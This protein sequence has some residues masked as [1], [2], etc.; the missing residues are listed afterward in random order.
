MELTVTYAIRNQVT[1]KT[2]STPPTINLI[3]FRQ[4]FATINNAFEQN[5]KISRT[6][7][8]LAFWDEK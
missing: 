8:L 7:S 2:T 5:K 1:E 3:S 4:I 6:L